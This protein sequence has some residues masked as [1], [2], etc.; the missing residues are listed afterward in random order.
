M[1]ASYKYVSTIFKVLFIASTLSAPLS[2]GA[3]VPATQS[4]P[5]LVTATLTGRVQNPSE[6][7]QVNDVAPYE[8]QDIV[9]SFA[10]NALT[11][12][13]MELRAKYHP[14]IPEEIVVAM[15]HS[16]MA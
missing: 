6:D 12:Q 5:S 11:L 16:I 4:K 14:Y 7:S 13:D 8:P 3:Q 2:L 10:P 9:D 15:E 1:K